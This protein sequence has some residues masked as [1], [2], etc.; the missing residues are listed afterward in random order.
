MFVLPCII[1]ATMQTT[2]KMQQLRLFIFLN[3]PYM[4]RATNTPILRSNFWL[5]I[6]L[7]VQCT[8]TAADRGTGRQ[9][10]RCIVPKAV[11]RV[12]RRS[13]E[14]A[15]LSPETCR[16]DLKRLTNEKVVASCKFSSLSHPIS[17]SH[18]LCNTRVSYPPNTSRNGQHLLNI[19][20]NNPVTSILILNMSFYDMPM[21]AQK[22]GG[23]W[24]STN[25]QPG[26]LNGVGSL[27]HATAA[28]RKWNT[29]CLL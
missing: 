9:Q 23:S 24:T 17:Y 8:D 6:Q 2:N 14:W 13:W 22:G 28:L 26:R 27:H 25:T 10:C 15:Y 11:Y 12:K 5:Y 18:L 29:R 7:L 16:A 20:T 19:V 4:F 3:Q 1:S 21:Q